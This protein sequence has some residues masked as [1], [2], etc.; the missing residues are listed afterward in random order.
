MKTGTLKCTPFSQLMNAATANNETKNT[1][2]RVLKMP[3]TLF[4]FLGILLLGA[5]S[6]S[7]SM[8]S[9]CGTWPSVNKGKY[10]Y[11]NSSTSNWSLKT[12]NN[13]QFANYKGYN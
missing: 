13:K 7:R 8:S 12:K 1:L 10:P 9:G 11:K 2:P 3:V 4:L 6:C 5:S